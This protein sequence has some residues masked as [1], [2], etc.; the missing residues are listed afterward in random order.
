MVATSK[1]WCECCALNCDGFREDCKAGTWKFCDK[2]C[3]ATVTCN[4]QLAP[5]NLYSTTSTMMTATA[6]VTTRSTTTTATT[7]NGV[8]NAPTPFPT[9]FST[10]FPTPRPTPSPTQAPSPYPTPMP[11]PPPP[12]PSSG[13]NSGDAQTVCAKFQS[14]WFTKYAGIGSYDDQN[15]RN[16]QPLTSGDSFQSCNA[17]FY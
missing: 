5:G 15:W 10:P 12:P 13:S 8:T 14:D 17:G 16:P 2:S 6:A 7:I 9:P 1:Q 3:N 11:T 4:P